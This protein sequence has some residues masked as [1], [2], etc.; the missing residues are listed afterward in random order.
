VSRDR[1]HSALRQ[2]VVSSAF[3]YGYTLTIW[4]SGA[5]LSH[6]RGLPTTV[7]AFLF[8]GGALIGFASV[9]LIAFGGLYS[10]NVRPPA[11][12]SL[13]EAFH[14]FSIG[15]AI[16]VAAVVAHTVH[17]VVAWP[18]DGFLA[19]VLYLTMTAIQIALVI[20]LDQEKPASSESRRR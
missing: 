7:D 17:S 2:T 18:L 12:F 13:W 10:K 11:V 19:T 6:A 15:L 8:M 1:Y 14:L 3:P 4:T 16:G 9:A 5:V 20:E